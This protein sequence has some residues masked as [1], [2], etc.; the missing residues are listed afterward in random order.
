[1]VMIYITVVELLSLTLHSKVQNLGF[2][3]WRRFLKIFAIYSHGS[4]LGNVN[5]TTY[6]YF[7]FTL[8]KDD[9]YEV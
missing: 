2:L 5:W 7:Q 8:P 3:F 4:H 1:M 9:P 6:I